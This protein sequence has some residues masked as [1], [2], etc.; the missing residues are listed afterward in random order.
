[1]LGSIPLDVNTIICGD[2]NARMPQRT[3]DHDE[4]VRGR[5]LNQWLSDHQ[6]QLWN[7]DMAYGIPT[8]TKFRQGQ[9]LQSIID[10]FTSNFPPSNAT[11]TIRTDLSLG[12]DHHL[13]SASFDL[14]P[15]EIITTTPPTRRMW[16]LSRLQ[17]TDCFELYESIFA[18]SSEPL[19]EQLRDLVDHPPT[20]TPN[21]DQLADS[22]NELIYDALTRSVGDRS[23]RP[24]HW[25]WF[26]SKSLAAAAAYRDTCYR[27]WRRAIGVEKAD[28]WTQ[29]REAH[30]AFRRDIKAAR[31]RAYQA[32]CNALERDFVKATSK[33]KVIRRRRQQQHSFVHPDEP[34]AAATVMSQHLASVCDGHLLSPDRPPSLPSLLLPH[35]TNDTPFDTDDIQTAI[36]KLPNRKAPGSD[37]LRAEMLKPIVKPLTPLLHSLFT[38]CWQWSYVP[39]PT[40][41]H[42]QVCP[43]F[44]KGDPT[45]AANYRPMSLTSILRKAMEYCLAPLLSLH[46]P[47]IDLA[48]GGFRPKRSAMDQALCLHEMMHL[49]RQAHHRPPVIAFLDIKAAYDTV[50]RNIIWTA[51]AATSTPPPLLSLLRHLFDDVTTSVLLSN[52]ISPPTSPATGV[53]QGSVLSPHLYSIYINTLPSVLREAATQLTTTVGSPPIPINSLLFADD[54][55]LLGTPTEVQ[56]M[57]D[58]AAAYSLKQGYRWSPTK[59]AVLNGPRQFTLYDEV[60]PTVDELS[61]LAYH[62]NALACPPPRCSRTAYQRLGAHLY[63]T[64][65]RPKFEYALAIS[66]FQVSDYRD[67]EQI[68]DRC[69][70]MIFG[71]HRRSSTAVFRHLCNLPTMRQR[72]TTLVFNPLAPHH[73][74]ASLRRNTLYLVNPPLPPPYVKE[75]ILAYRQE[76]L[77]QVREKRALMKGCRPTIGINPMLTV[78]ATRRERS[79]LMRWRMGWLP[80]QPRE[81]SCGNDHLSRR[82]VM[83]CPIIPSHFLDTLPAPPE[84]D[85]NAVDFAISALTTS[86]RL[87]PPFW[88]DLLNILLHVDRLIHPDTI[89]PEEPVPGSSWTEPSPNSGRSSPSPPP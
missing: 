36:K 27:K 50:D 19:L 1:M 55:A 34:S 18:A 80:G 60:L 3:G 12:S 49:F 65:I 38:I 74:L 5:T 78:P 28:W 48:Q 35:R 16:N 63:R 43:I 62:S 56:Q 75:I 87:P 45:M 73:R 9:T 51:L 68:Q 40:W 89:F 32:F 88:S 72:A 58:I 29:H 33:I 77:Q 2:F 64:F 8:Y 66:N 13:L 6:L 81:C 39:P 7:T 69:L 82:H 24:K 41:R 83:E 23:P 57:L 67:L 10:L 21:I 53:L 17:E 37:H 4:N 70:R 71:G 61:I 76:Q 47:V 86:P 85:Q 14:P 15:T 44:K 84:S 54:V 59:C 79:R 30:L 26:W 25:K 22:L 52:H 46:S 42:A 11:M 31:R 20:T